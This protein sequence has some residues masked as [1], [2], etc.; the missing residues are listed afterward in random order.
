MTASRAVLLDLRSALPPVKARPMP[1]GNPRRQPWNIPDVEDRCYLA[2]D[3]IASCWNSA[4]EAIAG[5]VDIVTQRRGSATN[6]TTVQSVG[7]LGSL[8]APKFVSA[9]SAW[10]GIQL[11]LSAYRVV[12]FACW[13]WWDAYANDNK[14]LLEYTPITTAGKN[15]WN[16]NPNNSSSGNFALN[17]AQNGTAASDQVTFSRT[18]FASVGA[19]HFLGA[20]FDMNQV[21]G[22]GGFPS[23]NCDVS[24][25][26][27]A[28]TVPTTLAV[29]FTGPDNLYFFS[30]A[31]S[32]NFADGRIAYFNMFR[33]LL[34]RGDML[35][36]Y[37]RPMA[38]LRYPESAGFR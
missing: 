19:W 1:F 38:L 10:A 14:L 22:G 24:T 20:G 27:V 15:G 36:L 26:A 6:L 12:S 16:V 21:A 23:V 25:P 7:R 13:F 8:L 17:K 32:S 37:N 5:P 28:S 33:R 34:T 11:D 30:R 9:N 18:T 3:L 29:N 31:G 4:V 35:F 2:K